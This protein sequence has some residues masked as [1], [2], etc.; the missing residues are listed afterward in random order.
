MAKKGLIRGLNKNEATT[1][2]SSVSAPSPRPRM[3]EPSCW[4]VTDLENAQQT[5]EMLESV[6]TRYPG[7]RYH[8]KLQISAMTKNFARDIRWSSF[9]CNALLELHQMGT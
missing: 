4:A 3:P 8:E 6:G 2:Q 7:T 5:H 9:S 1:D